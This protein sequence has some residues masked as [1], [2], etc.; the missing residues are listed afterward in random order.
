MSELRIVRAEGDPFTR[1]RV[2]G[3]AVRDLVNESLAFYDRYFSRRGVSSDQLEELLAPYLISA[4]A[5]FPAFLATL[6]G[7]AEG[8]TVPLHELFAINTFEELEPVL[9]ARGS[10]LFL[11]KK[12]GRIAEPKGASGSGGAAGGPERCSTVTVSGPGGT[13]LGHNEQ[14]LAADAGNIAFVIDIPDDESVPV[15][16]PTIVAC[17]PSVGVNGHGGVQGIDSLSAADDH[18]GVPRVFVSRSS[19]E[20]ADRDNAIALAGTPARAGGY[21]HVLAFPDAVTFTIET[22]GKELAVLDGPGCHTNHYL[23]PGLAKVG[24]GPSAGSRSRLTRLQELVA[25]RKPTDPAGVM[26]I[27]RDHAATP[28]GPCVHPDPADGDE[29]EAIMFS[30]VADVDRRRLW[31]AAGNPCRSEFQEI[32]LEGVW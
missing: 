12:E 16:G 8:A 27:L 28:E 24:A 3:R 29:A 11:E 13:I 18:V 9:E 30:V 4:E 5:R 6:K 7:M 1:G 22:T 19:L 15:A 17:L 2:V 21:A 31:V 20:A 14:W 23:D 10:E 25:E 32:D 26:D